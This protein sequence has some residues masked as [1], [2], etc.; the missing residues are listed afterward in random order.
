MNTFKLLLDGMGE[1]DT[2]ASHITKGCGYIHTLGV[3]GSQ[4]SHLIYSLGERKTGKTVVV[5]TDEQEAGRIVKELSFLT[6]REV[7]Y[8]PPR[9]YLYYDVDVSN[10]KS[11]FSRLKALASLD[12]SDYIVTTV[13]A[14]ASYTLPVDYYKNYTVNID[15]STSLDMEDFISSLIFIGYKRVSTVE[16]VGQFSVR[17][18]IVDVFSPS[19]DMPYRIEFWGD[20]IDSIRTFSFETQLSLESVDKAVICPARELIYTK[21]EALEVSEKIRKLKNENLNRDAERLISSHYFHSN[22]KYLPYFYSELP[23]LFDYLD[24]QTLYILSEPKELKSKFELWYKEQNEIITSLMDKGLF[25]RICKGY[26]I[27]YSDI[28]KCTSES[29]GVSMSALSHSTPDISPVEIISL[30]AKTLRAYTDSADYLVEDIEFWKKNS[31]RTIVLLSTDTKIR[32]LKELLSQRGISAVEISDLKR[33]PDFGE[34][35]IIKGTLER[36]FEYPSIKTA[37]V[38]DG[39]NTSRKHR[40]ISKPKD[41]KDA[42]KSFAEISVGDYVVH[43]THGVGKYVGIN[44]LEVQGVVRDYIKLKYKGTDCLYVPVEQLDLLYKYSSTEEKSVKLNSLGGTMWHKTVTKV[45]ESVANLAQDMI[46]LYAER[47]NIK[48]HTFPKDTD[49]QKQFEGDFLY[50]ETPD[51]LRCIEEVKN[52]MEQGKCMDRLLCGDVGYGKTEVALRAAFKT[53]MDGMQVAYLVPTTI[54]ASQHFNTFVS[55]M[56]EYCINVEMLSR[57]RTKKQQEQIIA[58][59]KT[60]EIDV[61]IGT[62]RIL[63]KDVEFKSLGLLIIDEEQ[64]FG[65]GHKEKLKEIKKN[66]NVLT[67]SATPI[68]RTLNMAMMGIRDLSVLASPPNDRAP[69]QTFVLEYNPIVVQNAIQRELARG[70][71]VYYLYNRVDSIERVAYS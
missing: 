5:A 46:K 47:S 27:T 8:F 66:V 23:T 36:G 42:I 24:F 14:L 40:K 4:K 44:Q 68:P 59:L 65:V 1:F 69:V 11:E 38:T 50:D 35:F 37:V 53:V 60:G 12:S 22:D 2:L 33:T 26:F 70:G 52:D 15:M 34:I 6:C 31:Y 9:E 29:V 62:H 21:K 67:L 20:D 45:K 61:V 48:G 19:G 56:K 13:S 25:P 32:N 7:L 39:E 57:F 63:Q 51:Q 43:R 41:A 10:R 28:V 3:S 58:K 18:S 30:S 17:G 16:S 49:W 55:R 71:Q 64:R 54:L